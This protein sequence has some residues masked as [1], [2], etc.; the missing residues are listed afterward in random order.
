MNDGDGLS[1]LTVLVLSDLNGNDCKLTLLL[2]E[3]IKSQRLVDCI[4]VTGS[5]TDGDPRQFN[6]SDYVAELL[7]RYKTV[8]QTLRQISPLVYFVQ[9]SNDPVLTIRKLSSYTNAESIVLMKYPDNNEWCIDVSFQ[10]VRIAPNLVI[11]G[12]SGSSASLDSYTKE[13][14]DIGADILWSDSVEQ[15]LTDV[16]SKKD[17]KELTLSSSSSTSLLQ[18]LLNFELQATLFDVLQSALMELNIVQASPDTFL[19]NLSTNST[20]QSALKDIDPRLF[21]K[22][23]TPDEIRNLITYKHTTMDDPIRHRCV[24]H[25]DCNTCNRNDPNTKQKRSQHPPYPFGP[26]FYPYVL[27]EGLGNFD[28]YTA[29]ALTLASQYA[30]SFN[31]YVVDLSA[32]REYFLMYSKRSAKL[33]NT[34]IL[35]QLYEPQPTKLTNSTNTSAQVARKLRSVFV[36]DTTTENINLPLHYSLEQ[37]QAHTA[38]HDEPMAIFIKFLL[39]PG[40]LNPTETMY[41]RVYGPLFCYNIDALP[42]STFQKLQASLS[43]EPDNGDRIDHIMPSTAI[44]SDEDIDVLSLST[45]T[46][47]AMDDMLRKE[48]MM[49]HSIVA[50][51]DGTSHDLH[52]LYKETCN[53]VDEFSSSS[54]ASTSDVSTYIRSMSTHYAKS[55]S[56]LP[57]IPNSLVSSFV[58]DGAT[59]TIETSPSI[60][61]GAPRSPT[62]APLT[63]LTKSHAGFSPSGTIQNYTS[64]LKSNGPK[65]SSQE[66]PSCLGKTLPVLPGLSSSSLLKEDPHKKVVEGMRGWLKLG[67]NLYDRLPKLWTDWSRLMQSTNKELSRLYSF[68][69]SKDSVIFLTHQGPAGSP[70]SYEFDRDKGEL[71][72]TGSYGLRDLYCANLNVLLHV[73]GRARRPLTRLYEVDDVSVFNPGTFCDGFYGIL[74]LKKKAGM[75]QVFSASIHKLSVETGNA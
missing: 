62:L 53:I 33:I 40:L 30:Q 70:T 17:T 27:Y 20:A 75:W 58:D 49:K 11:V 9:G 54:D 16:S 39:D 12:S 29:N 73:H 46:N 21:Y 65:V 8:L 5:L 25:D 44:Y 42:G 48:W 32:D 67:P 57:S 1:S 23:R 38:F 61:S 26:F 74:E 37:L 18:R 34:S 19:Q 56:N 24:P 51:R 50:I 13:A 43:A 7:V 66:S 60:K 63:P 52:D 69:A 47:N 10:A 45:P 55:Q 4:F 36:S 15:E 28:S 31:D 22:A 6:D 68:N 14:Y 71:L 72:E 64:Y 59:G 41:M 2:T 35:P 3:L